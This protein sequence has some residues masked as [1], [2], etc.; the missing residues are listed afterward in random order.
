MSGLVSRFHQL[1]LNVPRYWR[2]FG[3]K[4]IISFFVLRYA[5]KKKLRPLYFRGIRQPVWLRTGT[6]D[7]GV[8]REIFLD[9][10]Y[11]FKIEVDPLVIVDAGSNI[12]L[13]SVYYA[14]RF[15]RAMVYSIEPEKENFEVLEVN[16]KTFT[17]IIPVRA[18]LWGESTVVK[19][20]DPGRGEHGFVTEKSTAQLQ[21]GDETVKAITISDMLVEYDLDAIDILKMDIEGAEKEVFEH[22]Q[23]WVSKVSILIVEIHERFKPGCLSAFL[24]ATEGMHTLYERGKVVAKVSQ[25]LARKNRLLS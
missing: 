20:V 15:P 5:K 7:L 8:M 18:A 6:T 23:D 16:A 17:N 4:G 9:H 2:L 22:S 25:S 12:G 19:V 11:D 13:A 1:V 21:I 10:D 3:L 14:L 24:T